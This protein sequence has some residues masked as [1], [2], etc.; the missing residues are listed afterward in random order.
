VLTVLSSSRPRQTWLASAR[1]W[2]RL[3]RAALLLRG[4]DSPVPA[5]ARDQVLV[6]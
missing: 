5:P 6:G 3:P 1:L 4:T 2:E